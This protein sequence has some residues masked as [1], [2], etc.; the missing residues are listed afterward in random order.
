M[1][2]FAVGNAFYGDDGVGAAVLDRIRS[3]GRFPGAELVDVQTDALAL[4]DHLL[5]GDTAIVIDAARMGLT[6]GEV[7]S[8]RPDEVK[9]R[10]QEDHL[11]A[12]GF[13]LAETFALARKLG[14][15]PRD[16]LIIGVEPER[17]EIDKGLSAVVAAAVPRVISLIAAE[18]PA[19]V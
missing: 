10:I 2:I 4:L 7:V 12:H 13:S 3:E 18:V 6:P 1:K 9:L 5:P 17:I 15:M 8:F 19:D 11:T 14:K 16:I